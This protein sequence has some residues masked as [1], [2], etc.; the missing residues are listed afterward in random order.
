[1]TDAKLEEI[2]EIAKNLDFFE[3]LD[4]I[5]EVRAARGRIKELIVARATSRFH[6]ELLRQRDKQAQD[7]AATIQIQAGMLEKAREGLEEI[8]R[9]DWKL[10]GVNDA[11]VIDGSFA[12]IARKTLT[13]L[14]PSDQ[15]KE[16][17]NESTRKC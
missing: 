6:E 5:S 3:V 8:Q 7:D 14:T 9:G 12:A 4:L 13:Y 17:D 2:A 10:T 16:K 15:G 11:T 1:M